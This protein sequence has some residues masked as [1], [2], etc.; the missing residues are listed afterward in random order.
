MVKEIERKWLLPSDNFSPD[1]KF[2]DDQDTHETAV[3]R[4]S[5]N[6]MSATMP[7]VVH[8]G[9]DYDHL[10]PPSIF[11]INQIKV[12][13]SLYTSPSS[14]IRCSA[15]LASAD[16]TGEK[17]QAVSIP[18]APFMTDLYP[19]VITEY[20]YFPDSTL[21]S[22]SR[23]L[24]MTKH[25]YLSNNG[26]L[27][28]IPP[29]LAI[30]LFKRT[31]EKTTKQ[32]SGLTREEINEDITN[33][34]DEHTF[35]S[36]IK[37]NIFPYIVKQRTEF[38]ISE[39]MKSFG[40]KQIC[41]DHFPSMELMQIC[42]ANMVKRFEQSLP[43][44]MSL[45]EVIRPLLL[46]IDVCKFESPTGGHKVSEIIKRK[47]DSVSSWREYDETI[48][49]M[50]VNV[51]PVILEI[52]FENETFANAFDI[53]KLVGGT[54]LRPVIIEEI[55]NNITY[56]NYNISKW[57]CSDLIQHRAKIKNFFNL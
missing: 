44:G 22:N 56:N 17:Y 32:G 42:D 43:E 55:T 10:F 48:K 38:K 57:T 2:V 14:R 11:Q 6:N 36:V 7:K 4:Q 19:H 53:N 47:F 18:M 52:E 54:M 12:L 30:S 16:E 21:K 33:E 46:R 20:K 24:Q 50:F 3:S 49:S 25:A 41:Y 5:E 29:S 27:E 1:V 31:Y 34:I 45:E 13:I 9:D 26:D 15:E 51:F 39:K 35:F 37:S 23:T 40:I 28:P 8:P